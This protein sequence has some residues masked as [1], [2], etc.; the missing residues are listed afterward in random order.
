MS[1]TTVL[2]PPALGVADEERTSR[3]VLWWAGLGA[4]F[5]VLGVYLAL[6]WIFSGPSTTPSGPTEPPLYMVINAWAQQIVGSIGAVF[7]LYWFVVR[8]WR[9]DGRISWDGMFLLA[10]WTVWWQDAAVNWI[11]NNAVYNTATML[12]WGSWYGL[13]PGWVAPNG[14]QIAEPLLF[15]L[16]W[17]P[18]GMLVAVIFFNFVMRKA[19]ARWPRLGLVGIAGVAFAV[20]ALTDLVMEVLYVASGLY[21]YPTA[22]EPV[23]LF[24]GHYYQFPLY[25]PIAWGAVWT[26]AA[27]LR[28]VKNDKGQT[29]VERGIDKVKTGRLG[30]SKGKQWLRF[31]AIAGVLNLAFVCFYNI[32][33]AIIN[34]L[35]AHS[36]PADIQKRSYFTQGMCGEGTQYACPGPSNPLNRKDSVHVSPTGE[37]V[38]P[39]GRTFPP[40]VP[41]AP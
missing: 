13:I 5:C 16:T 22:L 3:P 12:Q 40:P 34:S 6:A 28:Y 15:S 7:C 35:Y 9:R 17:Y 14:N 36:W 20:S 11:T 27:C 23:T 26:V 21:V 32:P 4:A 24:A 37:L 2:A 10:A 18:Y 39:P 31:L 25:E 29:F 41:Y 38:V 1:A 33:V 8:P 30:T 19:K